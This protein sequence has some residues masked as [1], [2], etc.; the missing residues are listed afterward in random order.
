MISLLKLDL[1]ESDFSMCLGLLMSYKEPSN[2]LI[3]LEQASKVRRSIVDNK[4]YD[5]VPT[6]VEEEP[7]Q[8]DVLNDEEE[9]TKVPNKSSF[10][11]P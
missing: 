3:V 6:P 10:N 11:V 4:K 9:E 8:V 5:R 1:L 2:P 7:I